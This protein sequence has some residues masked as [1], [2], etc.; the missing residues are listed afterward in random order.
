[1]RERQISTPVLIV[2]TG[3]SGL[4][5]A[6]ELAEAGVDVLALARMSAVLTV[7]EAS[8]RGDLARQCR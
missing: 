6:I 3:G 7:A 2:G 5:A 4:R 1:M 8:H